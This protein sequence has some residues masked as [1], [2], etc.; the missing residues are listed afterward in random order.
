MNYTISQSASLELL[1]RLGE[2]GHRIFSPEKARE[3]LKNPSDSYIRQ[4]LHGLTRNGWLLRLRRGIYAL[5]PE[6]FHGPPIHEFEVAMALAS[7]AAVSHWS[8]LSVHGLTEQIPRDVFVLTTGK[9]ATPRGPVCIHGSPFRFC[10]VIPEHYFGTETI[11]RGEIPITVTDPER[12]LLDGLTRPQ[13]CGDIGVV[14]QAFECQGSL[15]LERI[16]G[17]ARR[18]G[19]TCAKRLGWVLE[20]QGVSGKLLQELAQLPISGYRPLDPTASRRGPCNARWNIIENLPGR[21]T[22]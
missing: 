17:Y 16:I 20:H 18:L 3:L 7:P 13:L 10:R 15:N 1:Q 22:H 4:V 14:L 9:T 21:A 19:V 12:T 8:A 2:G 11:W 5:S 6:V